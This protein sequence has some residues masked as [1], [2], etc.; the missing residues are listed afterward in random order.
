MDEQKQAQSEKAARAL[1]DRLVH[2][3]AEQVPRKEAINVE[4]HMGEQ[5][6][7]GEDNASRSS[8]RFVLPDGTMLD[9]RLCVENVGGNMYCVDASVEDHSE[10]FSI[11]LP[12]AEMG[13]EGN[14]G[15]EICDYVFEEV[16]RSAGEIF[17]RET[18]SQSGQAS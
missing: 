11:S 13:A 7:C 1:C 6:T 3:F 8:L 16:K 15:K 18:S 17:L 5:Q 2:F 10:T 12:E 14:Y 9:G 4:V